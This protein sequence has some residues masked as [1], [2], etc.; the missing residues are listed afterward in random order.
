MSINHYPLYPFGKLDAQSEAVLNQIAESNEKPLSSVTLQE[1]RDSFLDKSWLGDPDASIRIND[2]YIENFGIKIPL[3]IYVPEGK[4][5]FP[6][7]IYFHGGGFVLGALKEFDSFCTLIAGGARALVISV[8]YRLAPENKYPAAV[9]T[10]SYKYFGNGFWLP[11]VNI[12]WY[13]NHYLENIGQAAS[14]LVSPLLAEKLDGLPRALII[15]SEFDVLRDEGEKYANQLEA[16]SV[17][18]KYSNYK[19][20]L[21]DFVVLPGKFE[22][23]KEAINEICSTLREVFITRC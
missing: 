18:V 16:E 21:H 20:V 10:N 6:I 22:R 15:T 14:H 7:V 1:A 3:R 19:G 9:E 23:A 13:R 4:G 12:N 2:T 5:S 17:F 8:G 11:L